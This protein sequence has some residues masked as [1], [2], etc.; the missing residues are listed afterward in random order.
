[1]IN[2]TKSTASSA[3]NVSGTGR[4]VGEVVW[5]VYHCVS[6]ITEVVMPAFYLRSNLT[7]KGRPY[8][9]ETHAER[10]HAK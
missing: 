3:D 4:K 10:C 6:A 1:M 7:N 9:L 2:S 5:D 8:E